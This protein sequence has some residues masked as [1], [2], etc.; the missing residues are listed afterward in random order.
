MRTLQAII[1]CWLCLYFTDFSTSISSSRQS[2]QTAQHY[3]CPV[4]GK[5]I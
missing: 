4:E 5:G 2:T 1:K 3:V